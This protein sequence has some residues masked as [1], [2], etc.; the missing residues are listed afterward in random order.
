MR[1]G[2]AFVVDSLLGFDMKKEI[3]VIASGKIITG[4]HIIRAMALGADMASSARSMMLAL[5][6][7]QALECNKNTCPTGIATQ[8]QGLMAGLAVSDKRVRVANYHKETVKA[9]A[10]LLAAAGLEAAPD[11][12][13]R[14]LFRRCS[15]MQVCRFDEIYPY[16][17]TGCLLR[18]DPPEWLR[19]DFDEAS[20]N[21]FQPCAS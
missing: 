16:P 7:I 2:L 8:T 10:E 20:P 18:D 19:R 4:F 11:L 15:M 6:C 9:V 13:R 3:S 17:E 1:E 12:R 14:H 21:S 5:G